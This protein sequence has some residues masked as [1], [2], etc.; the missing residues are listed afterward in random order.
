MA[1]ELS[2][3]DMILQQKGLEFAQKLHIKNEVKYDSRW[4]YRFKKRHSL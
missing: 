1:V 4:I 3:S 2:L